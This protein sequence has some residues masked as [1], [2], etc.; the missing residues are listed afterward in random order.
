[1]VRRFGPMSLAAIAFALACSSSPTAS[2]NQSSR[3][4]GVW[5]N[6]TVQLDATADE[7]TLTVLCYGTFK[8][9]GALELNADGSFAADGVVSSSAFNLANGLKVRASGTTTATTTDISISVQDAGGAWTSPLTFHL[10]VGVHAATLPS[11]PT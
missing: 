9:S 3:L 1:M 10:N 8:F 6:S 2:N 7:A 5:G 11:C 4:T